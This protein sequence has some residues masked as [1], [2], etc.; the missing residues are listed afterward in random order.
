[1][2]LF[3][4]P[5]LRKQKQAVKLATR[6]RQQAARDTSVEIDLLV[7]KHMSGTHASVAAYRADGQTSY[8][9]AEALAGAQDT[10]AKAGHLA[11]AFVSDFAALPDPKTT[12]DFEAITTFELEARAALIL[13]RDEARHWLAALNAAMGSRLTIAANVSAQAW[14]HSTA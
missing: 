12:A 8:A 4:P 3:D 9:L 13:L 14:P 2:G 6:L 10:I 11:D 7:D 1:M 5:E